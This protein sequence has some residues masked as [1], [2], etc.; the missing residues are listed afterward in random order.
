MKVDSFLVAGLEARTTNALEMSGKGIIAKLWSQMGQPAG[1]IVAVYYDYA[2]DRDGAYTYLLGTKVSAAEKIPP[3]MV[4]HEVAGGDYSKF[5]SSGANPAEAVVRLWQ[6]IWNL[7]K[8]SLR[9]AYKTDFEVYQ[10]NGDIDI[11]IGVLV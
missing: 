11:Y 9:R 3:G 7:E 6:E 10:P 5:S 2:S 8:T 4:A 1:P